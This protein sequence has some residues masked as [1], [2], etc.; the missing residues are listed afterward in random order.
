MGDLAVYWRGSWRSLDQETGLPALD[1]RGRG[2]RQHWNSRRSLRKPT[3]CRNLISR[4]TMAQKEGR[5]EES[6]AIARDHRA[7]RHPGPLLTPLQENTIQHKS[8]HS[9]ITVPA[10]RAINL[11]TRR[12]QNT[13]QAILPQASGH[14]RVQTSTCTQV[15]MGFANWQYAALNISLGGSMPMRGCSQGPYQAR[16]ESTHMGLEYEDVGQS[17]CGGRD[18]HN[19]LAKPKK[20]FYVLSALRFGD[21]LLVGHH[22]RGWRLC[23]VGLGPRWVQLAPHG[24]EKGRGIASMQ[25]VVFVAMLDPPVQGH[26]SQTSMI[27]GRLSARLRL[28]RPPAFTG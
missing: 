1:I 21:A 15:Q 25:P 18:L 9:V 3:C 8:P 13:G 10:W 24:F 12:L 28:G 22:G 20:N 16:L 11:R 27:S 23:S 5:V 7:F 2:F 6:L 26:P 17:S 14:Q 4:A 19:A